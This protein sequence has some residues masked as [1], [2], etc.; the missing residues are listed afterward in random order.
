MT[1]QEA[2]KQLE[3][4]REMCLFNPSTGE[5]EP[6][7]EDCRKS[8]EALGLAIEALEDKIP[9][10]IKKETTDV[11]TYYCVSCPKCNKHFGYQRKY[12]IWMGEE[13]LYCNC[14]QRLDWSDVDDNIPK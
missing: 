6:M 12:N 9:R 4:D 14:G 7:N 10:K 11:R 5:E 8:A 1:P 13:P 3:Y 2:I